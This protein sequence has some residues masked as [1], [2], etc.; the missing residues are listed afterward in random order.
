VLALASQLGGAPDRVLV[1]GCE[2]AVRMRGE[3]EEIV[4]ELS[5]PVRVALD[6]AV[7]MVE[8]L[9]AELVGGQRGERA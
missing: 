3:E 5:E 2:P 9:V 4:G 6:E 8:T 1:V 7:N